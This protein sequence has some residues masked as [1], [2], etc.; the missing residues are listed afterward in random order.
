MNNEVGA[1]RLAATAAEAS[2]LW[3]VVEL[4]IVC[5]AKE[6]LEASDGLTLA[7]NR[8]AT[9]VVTTS[10]RRREDAS[11]AFKTATLSLD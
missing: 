11:V 2:V 3:N 6:T 1:A 7:W 4:G 9:P 5:S 8:T 10:N